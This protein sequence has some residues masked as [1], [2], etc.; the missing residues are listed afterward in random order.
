MKAGTFMQKTEKFLL[1]DSDQN[2]EIIGLISY[3][4]ETKRLTIE[5]IPPK[6]PEQ[7]SEYPLSFQL[8]IQSGCREL[9]EKWVELW[10]SDRVV[11]PERQGLLE[12]LNEHG[13]AEYDEFAIMKLAGG[14]N[15]MDGTFWEQVSDATTAETILRNRQ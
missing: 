8:A 11:P 9:P 2:G 12:R 6:S 3:S 4:H 15:T 1:K 13:V 10:I 7:L 14:K 5:P